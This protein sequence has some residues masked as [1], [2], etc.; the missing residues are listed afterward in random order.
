MLVS[1]PRRQGG[2]LDL[3]RLVRGQ[4]VHDHV[5]LASWVGGGHVEEEVDQGG[6][7]VAGHRLA[8]DLA[9]LCVEDR[10]QREGSMPE[11]LK[12]VPF[13]AA[14]RE[15]QDR[16]ESVQRLNGCFLVDRDDHRVFRGI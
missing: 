4:I 5:D 15:R 14:G 16:I 9:G 8:H 1:R 10:V 2:R 7:R 3:L 6:T 11:V 12:A 13:R